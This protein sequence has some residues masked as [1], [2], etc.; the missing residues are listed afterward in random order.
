MKYYLSSSDLLCHQ[1]HH[2]SPLHQEH[3]FLPDARVWL[4]L[5]S[6]LKFS[7]HRQSLIFIHRPAG[8]FFTSLG[9]EIIGP[10]RRRCLSFLSI[11]G[12]IYL[13]STSSMESAWILMTCYW[14]AFSDFAASLVFFHPAPISNLPEEACLQS[15]FS[16]VSVMNVTLA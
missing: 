7:L 1:C 11:P 9:C 2:C 12:D 14:E 8:Q 3:L 15:S 10:W 5:M 16:L 13:C 4:L 6:I